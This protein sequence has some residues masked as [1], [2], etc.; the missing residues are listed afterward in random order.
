[1]KRLFAMFL[2]LIL[3]LAFACSALAD[4]IIAPLVE[5]AQILLFDT[6]NVTLSGHADFS[7][8]GERFKTA[9]IL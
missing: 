4:G 6:E 5:S 7:L 8:N 1:M 3:L 2:T 9:D